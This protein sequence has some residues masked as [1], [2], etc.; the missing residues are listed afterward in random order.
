MTIRR[1]KMK[2]EQKT[3]TTYGHGVKLTA[4]YGDS[5]ENK[6]F[7]AAT[8]SGVVEMSVV[9]PEVAAAFELGKEY[10]VDF[11]PVD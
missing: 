8:P 7:F 11:V 3:Q 9:K 6:A 4:V 5:P 1:A 10:Y 2:V